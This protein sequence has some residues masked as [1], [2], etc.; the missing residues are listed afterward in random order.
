M[1]RIELRLHTLNQHTIICIKVFG[2]W[3]IIRNAMNSLSFC[4]VRPKRIYWQKSYDIKSNRHPEMKLKDWPSLGSAYSM[5]RAFTSSNIMHIMLRKSSKTMNVVQQQ[6]ITNNNLNL[7]VL[8][9]LLIYQEAN[10]RGKLFSCFVNLVGLRF[11]S[12]AERDVRMRIANS[13]AVSLSHYQTH[14]QTAQY[15]LND[16]RSKKLNGNP[17][18]IHAWNCSSTKMAG[19]HVP[20]IWFVCAQK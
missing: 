8:N 3:R 12:N 1:I 4:S 15:N 9:N 16:F 17:A 19:V 10:T 2:D 20:S 6:V 13:L 14:T 5:C 18:H 7:C 11:H